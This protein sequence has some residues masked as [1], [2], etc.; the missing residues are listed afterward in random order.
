VWKEIAHSVVDDA[1]GPGGATAGIRARNAARLSA[2]AASGTDAAR[3]AI[4]AVA[5]TQGIDPPTRALASA[6]RG[7]APTRS[8]AGA[9]IRG[10]VLAP[11]RRGALQVLRWVSGWALVAWIA[12]GVGSLLG[13]RR[14]AELA[15][16]EKGLELREERF[17]LG[18]K[19][20]EAVSELALGSIVEAGR[21][22][23]YPSLHL[24]VGV[25]ALSFG[26]LFGGL[27]LFDGARSGELT[28]MLAGAALA[29]SGAGLDLALD[30]LVPARRG[31]VSVDLAVHRGRV[32][33]LGRVPLDEADRFLGALRDRA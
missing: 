24:L 15:L 1:S 6:L 14:D 5:E 26:L 31:R 12:R 3:A 25:L 8:A 4:D 32:V 13:I 7:G 33:R 30:V 17:V 21:E 27:V 23:R 22:V 11:R 2:L 18:R 20:G 16:G 19:V 29:L 10:R 28:L 9:R